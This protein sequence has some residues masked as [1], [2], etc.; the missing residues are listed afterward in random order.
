MTALGPDPVMARP[1]RAGRSLLV[2]GSGLVGAMVLAAIVVPWL[3]PWGP[4]EID[5]AA[6]LA[7][8]SGVHLFG[9]DRDG[10][11]VFVRVFH[12]AR[13]DLSLAVAAVFL[14]VV[15][16]GVLGSVVGY[17][18][19]WLDAVVMRVM[20]MFQAFPAFV[21]ALAV[22][23]IVSG[24]SVA[25]VGVLALVN[26]PSYVRLMRTEVRSL[27]DHTFVEAA[28]VTGNG[29]ASIL[30]R[31][32]VPNALRPVLVVAPL[33]CGWA[34]LILAGLSFVGLGVEVPRAEWGAMISVGAPDVVS[35]VW[36]TSV[37]PGV[38]LFLTVL[39]LNLIGEGLLDRGRRS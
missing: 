7:A 10:M 36:W 29:P 15:A 13:L 25:L 6:N 35:G 3:S 14:A 26:A 22:A 8:P 11:D 33:N 12:A 37:F 4:L 28:R 24:G 5:S 18:G 30:F 20:D 2:Y 38:A 9:T 27:R 19:G 23:A 17:R 39:G 31:H 32:V 21:L 16:G 1:G 34:M